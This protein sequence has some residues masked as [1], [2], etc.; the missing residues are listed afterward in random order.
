M[1]T[2]T[3]ITSY[4]N[5]VLFVI[6]ASGSM[7]TRAKD[8]IKV[9]DGQV[10]YLAR[11]SQ[12]LDQETRITAFMFDDNVQCLVYDKDVLRMPSL[13][14]LYRIGGMTALID[15][16]MDSV[17]DLRMT[18]EKYGDH[19][20]LG[21][22][23]TDGDENASRRPNKGQ[24]LATMLSNLPEN[25]TLAV[26]VPNQI[27]VD[28]SKKWGFP[29]NNIAIWDTTSAQGFA[30]AAKKIMAATENFMVGRQQGLRSSKN[31][32]TVDTSA[33]NHKTVAATLKKVDPAKYVFVPVPKSANVVRTEIRPHVEASIKGFSYSTGCAF[34]QLTKPEVIQPD[35]QVCV[36]NKHTKELY[37]GKEARDLIGLPDVKMKVQP[38]ANAAFE[39]FVQSNSVN[40]LLV[41]ETQ[42]LVFK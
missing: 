2:K 40:R 17:E 31:L 4:I 6:D 27:G 32:F 9:F 10:Q 7:R 28:E 21:Y 33:L 34:Y 38:G 1:S 42:V 18:P 22:V 5:H 19:A 36:L 25:W 11:R 39:I 23:I 30:E 24:V 29:A 20:F 15:A 13:E 8:V 12:E 26:L 14:G 37:E 35:K 3:A 41:G 16:V